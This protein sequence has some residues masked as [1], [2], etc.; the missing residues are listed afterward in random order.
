MR[1]IKNRKLPSRKNI[2]CKTIVSAKLLQFKL[3][4]NTVMLIINRT[5][6]NVFNKKIKIFIPAARDR[7][8][9]GEAL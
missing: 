9:S 8:D 1:K 7:D 4:F 3:I 6:Y 5:D 2:F